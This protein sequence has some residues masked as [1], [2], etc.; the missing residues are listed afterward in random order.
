MLAAVDPRAR[1]ASS[2]NAE[3]RSNSSHWCVGP[4]LSWLAPFKVLTNSQADDGKLPIHHAIRG[5][6]CHIVRLLLEEES[7]PQLQAESFLE[8]VRITVEAPSFCSNLSPKGIQIDWETPAGE[9]IAIELAK[10]GFLS[11]DDV[12]K[13]A[14]EHVLEVL[15]QTMAPL[16]KSARS[17]NS[18]LTGKRLLPEGE[19][20]LE[21]PD[22]KKASL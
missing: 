8:L 1:F 20:L 19:D 11:E 10:R 15:Q 17:D 3:E 18:P 12:R 5:S 21:L 9:L 2:L 6:W 22:P 14:P 7:H 13:H 4:C 16:P